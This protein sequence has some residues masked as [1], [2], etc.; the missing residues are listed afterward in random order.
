MTDPK[1][2]A[3]EDEAGLWSV[4]DVESDIPAVLDGVPQVGLSRD[5]AEAVADTLNAMTD[6]EDG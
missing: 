5:E 1:Y 2:A 3:S 4:I 6:D